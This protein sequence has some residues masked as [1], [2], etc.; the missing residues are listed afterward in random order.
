MST[1]VE[2][3]SRGAAGDAGPF[4]PLRELAAAAGSLASACP[5]AFVHQARALASRHRDGR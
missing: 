5:R 2:T 4:A 3:R 1:G